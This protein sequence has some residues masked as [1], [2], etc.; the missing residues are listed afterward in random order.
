MKKSLFVTLIAS[1]ALIMISCGS[2]TNSPAKTAEKIATA[3][4]KGDY[5]TI[6]ENV[7]MGDSE[8]QSKEEIEGQKQML[9]GLLK[10]KG[11]KSIKENG[12]IKTYEVIEE[13]VAEDGKTAKVKMKYTY[14][15]GSEDTET[16]SF[17]KADDKWFLEIDK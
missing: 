13:T 9:E 17:V 14:N 10:E 8:N 16:M 12:G 7:Y 11:A 5:K 4:Q 2:K 3:L 15:N 6:V 1:F